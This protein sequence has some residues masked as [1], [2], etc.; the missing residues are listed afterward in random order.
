MYN[1]SIFLVFVAVCGHVDILNILVEHR[2]ELSTA[3]SHH[4]YPI[5]YAAQ[6]NSKEQGHSD[7]KVGEKVL[8]VLLDQGVPLDVLDKD[9]RQPLLWAASAG[10]KIWTFSSIS[11]LWNKLCK[12]YNISSL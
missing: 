12:K 7:P 5:H 10:I 8:K 1:N 11:F 6:M 9:G 4:A 2:A 3:D